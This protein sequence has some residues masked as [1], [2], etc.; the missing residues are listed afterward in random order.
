[1]KEL[2]NVFDIADGIQIARYDSDDID[3][4]RTL[5]QVMQMYH[6]ENVKLTKTNVISD[7]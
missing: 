7:T 5:R 4:D 1:M 3:H 2:P 6:Q